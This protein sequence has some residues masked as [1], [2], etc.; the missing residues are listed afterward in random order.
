M[1]LRG[2]G[3][4]AGD[5]PYGGDTALVPHTGGLD[6]MQGMTPAAVQQAAA[7]DPIKPGE[8]LDQY[9]QRLSSTMM[10]QGGNTMGLGSFSQNWNNGLKQM[11]GQMLAMGGGAAIPAIAP[12]LGGALGIGAAGGGAVAGA[13]CGAAES[14]L[15][16]TSVGKGALTGA[17]GGAFTGGL[18]KDISGAVTDTLTPADPTASYFGDIG[19]SAD[20]NPPWYAT[21]AG[22]AASGAAKGGL[23][24]LATGGNLV[25]GL[26]T[27]AAGGGVNAGVKDLTGGTAAQPF[28]P[29]IGGVATSL[30]KTAIT[31]GGT[32]TANVGPSTP[33]PSGSGTGPSTT[34]AVPTAATHSSSVG[35]GTGAGAG[36][37][38]STKSTAGQ[39]MPPAAPVGNT[40]PT[41]VTAN[42]LPVPGAPPAGPGVATPPTAVNPA[43]LPGPAGGAPTAPITA[44]GVSKDATQP[45]ATPTAPPAATPDPTGTSSG[46]P[47]WLSSLFPG[48][49]ANIPPAL[50]A[51]L[52][53]YEAS[54]QKAQNQTEANTLSAL[55]TPLVN[56]SNTALTQAQMGTLNPQQ[57]ALQQSQLSQGKTL[58]GQAGPL[59]DIANTGF[60]QFQAGALPAW[61]Q[62][63]LDQ[64]KAAATAQLKQ[65][66]GSQV[67]S[68]ALAAQQ[69]Q[70]DQQ[71]DIAKGQL[72]IQNL[73]Q[74]EQA[75]TMGIN[76]QNMGYADIQ[77]GY[78]T[79]V[80]AIQQSYN[81][82]ISLATSGFGPIEQAIQLL[83]QGDSQLSSSLMEMFGLI[84]MGFAEAQAKN[85]GT[86]PGA[87]P[88]PPAAAP[89]GAPGA[90]GAPGVGPPNSPLNPPGGSGTTIG[91]P[92]PTQ[93]QSNDPNA[94]NYQPSNPQVPT[95]TSGT[96]LDPSQQ[97]PG[98]SV[99]QNPPGGNVPGTS[100]SNINPM[101]G[102]P[103]TMG[104]G[105][106]PGTLQ[107]DPTQ[108]VTDP[109]LPPPDVFQGP[110]D[111]GSPWDPG[112][113]TT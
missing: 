41:N 85:K 78:Q 18:G 9:T 74:S 7:A 51:A 82:A 50:M 98:T 55:G 81:N 79:G 59:L 17:V 100:V 65:S 96:P 84:G 39:G 43:L 37:D 107:P 12:A 48:G 103:Y 62:A 93:F 23:T 109:G 110:I 16:G 3:I 52:G 5:S 6:L 46:I 71:Y 104:G 73:N 49:A 113:N 8:T 1:G 72:M 68:S 4:A 21:T 56:A 20:V 34:P 42:T 44:P 66:L 32:S 24:S 106:P 80:N 60:A 28:A 87:T 69:T 83:I 11:L 105:T 89:P 30:A 64:Q 94:P 40:D 91:G 19:G 29:E 10:A 92:W 58:T 25:T 33:G 112:S 101:T 111:T 35:S 99:Q 26:E 63:E 76:T 75:F 61:Q 22:G 36:P 102:Q 38:T 13:G 57:S 2:S 14:G 47:S 27:G 54:S 70:I 67:D 90:P 31:G 97:V 86:T 53:I 95:L 77:A 15:A 45:G 108:P 88:T